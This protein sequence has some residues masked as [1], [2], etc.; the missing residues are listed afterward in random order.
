MALYSSGSQELSI[1]STPHSFSVGIHLFKN[2]NNRVKD[3]HEKPLADKTGSS[4]MLA[5]GE[6]G[7]PFLFSVYALFMVVF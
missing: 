1:L 5:A 6:M 7:T 4:N 3:R 2:R